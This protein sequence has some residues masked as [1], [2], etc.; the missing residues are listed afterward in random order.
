LRVS[1]FQHFSASPLHGANGARWQR[2]K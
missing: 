2:C 1:A